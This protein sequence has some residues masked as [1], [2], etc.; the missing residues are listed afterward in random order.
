MISIAILQCIWGASIVTQ[1]INLLLLM[2]ASHFGVIDWVLAAL[3]FIHLPAKVPGKIVNDVSYVGDHMHF[4]VPD[5]SLAQAWY[6]RH[7]GDEPESGRYLSVSPSHCV[8]VGERFQKKHEEKPGK[9]GEVA[10][11]KTRREKKTINSTEKKRI[12][13]S[14]GKQAGRE[15][16]GPW[17]G[18][19]SPAVEV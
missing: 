12:R 19:E 9:G 7:L 8:A 13:W 11:G 14:W 1:C 15:C 10:A 16:T 3:L 4:W 2:L 6:Y 5:F 17:L 18:N